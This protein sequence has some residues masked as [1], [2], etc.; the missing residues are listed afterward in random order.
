MKPY[1]KAKVEVG[2][3]V[4]ERWILAA[5]RDRTFFS[6][7]ELSLAV[8]EHLVLLNERS[9]QKMPGSRRQLFTSEEQ[10]TLRPL[11]LFP[12]VFGRRRRARVHPD[13]HVE[14]AGHY[15]S[16][17]YGLVREEVEL[18]YTDSTLEV[19]HRG[20]RVAAHALSCAKGRATT[21]LEHLP[22]GQRAYAEWTPE[23]FISW[24]EKTGPATAE[25]VRAILAGRSHPAL[26]FRSCM[27][28][29]HLGDRFG[30]ERLEAA[31]RRALKLRAYSYRSLANTLEHHLEE[32]PLPGATPTP[33]PLFHE[34]LRGPDYFKS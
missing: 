11:P 5:L 32:Q 4:A 33:E 24:A 3:L 8:R 27:G 29:L 34:N 16:V 23:R 14:L 22:P 30:K 7:G 2:V 13:G 6:L 26:G 25:V 15:Y 9:F 31:A 28:V 18:L 17:P 12:Y 21:C 1:D 19:F 20:V 10:P